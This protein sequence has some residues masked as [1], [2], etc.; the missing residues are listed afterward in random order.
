MTRGKH[1]AAAP[2][3]RANDALSADLATYQAKVAKQ[4]G[5]IRELRKQLA[6]CQQRYAEDTR[7]LTE[8]AR[9][10]IWP[11]LTAAR[12][13]IARLKN[14]INRRDHKQHQVESRTNTLFGRVIDHLKKDHGMDG[15]EA[16]E[17]T[18]QWAGMDAGLL[19]DKR[20]VEAANAGRLTREQALTLDKRRR[21]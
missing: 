18:G 2:I 19:W 20:L 5:E 7:A 9:L 16:F 8:Q 17:T 4:A 11:E 13:T 21:P 6:V 12:E 10:G 1:G 3:R 15:V 14:E